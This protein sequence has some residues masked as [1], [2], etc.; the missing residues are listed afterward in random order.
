MGFSRNENAIVAFVSVEH[1]FCDRVGPSFV[2]AETEPY[3]EAHGGASE[4]AKPYSEH[5]VIAPIVSITI[6]FNQFHAIGIVLRYWY[7]D[8]SI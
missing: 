8:F 6:G 7:P 4:A 5:G 2:L 1:E 3:R